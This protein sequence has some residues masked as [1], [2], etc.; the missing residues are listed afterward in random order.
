M[1]VFYLRVNRYYS[2]CYRK[3]QFSLG[4]IILLTLLQKFLDLSKKLLSPK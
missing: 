1:K 2:I 4:Y 3:K